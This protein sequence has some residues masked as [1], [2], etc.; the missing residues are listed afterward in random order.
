MRTRA[1][2]LA[3]QDHQDLLRN[4]EI[5]RTSIL[6]EFVISKEKVEVIFVLHF[7]VEAIRA[8]RFSENSSLLGKLS[9]I[10]YSVS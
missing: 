5:S 8:L 9:I 7:F 3:D 1:Q 2:D 4:Q 10:A 6:E